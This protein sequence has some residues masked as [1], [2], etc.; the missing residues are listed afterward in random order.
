[1]RCRCESMYSLLDSKRVEVAKGESI[2]ELATGNDAGGKIKIKGRIATEIRQA[3]PELFSPKV[4][5]VELSREITP[6]IP[7]PTAPAHAILV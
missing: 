5:N 6:V 4:Q 3:V 2:F 1:M 7:M